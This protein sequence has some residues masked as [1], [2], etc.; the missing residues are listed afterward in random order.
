VFGVFLVPSTNEKIICQK[1]EEPSFIK[2]NIEQLHSPDGEKRGG[3]DAASSLSP[4]VMQ[5]SSLLI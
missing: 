1:R 5:V 2:S 4:L 3:A